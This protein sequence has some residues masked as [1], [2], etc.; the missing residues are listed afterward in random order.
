MRLTLHKKSCISYLP[1]IYFAKYWLGLLVSVR[2]I[3]HFEHYFDFL[4]FVNQNNI[5]FLLVFLFSKAS[6][7]SVRDSAFHFS[8]ILSRLIEMLSQSC[9]LLKSNEII[10]SQTSSTEVFKDIKLFPASESKG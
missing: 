2:I 7:I 6:Q 1:L 9:V 8:Q 3:R 5:S 4:L 10:T